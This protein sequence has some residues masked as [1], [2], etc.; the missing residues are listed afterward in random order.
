MYFL[1]EP[2]FIQIETVTT[3]IDIDWYALIFIIFNLMQF[4]DSIEKKD[5]S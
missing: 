3:D 1:W 4:K 5:I 2:R